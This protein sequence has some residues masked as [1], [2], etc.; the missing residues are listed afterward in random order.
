MNH[1]CRLNKLFDGQFSVMKTMLKPHCDTVKVITIFQNK[2]KIRPPKDRKDKN[3]KQNNNRNYQKK[4]RIRQQKE[5]T[6]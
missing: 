4:R 2:S 1:C 6:S 5:F 3:E